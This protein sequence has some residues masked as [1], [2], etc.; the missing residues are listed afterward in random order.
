M[1]EV[2]HKIFKDVFYNIIMINLFKMFNEIEF[3]MKN[4][5]CLLINH[6]NNLKLKNTCV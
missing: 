1:I 5:T 2:Y 6:N 3:N 4:K